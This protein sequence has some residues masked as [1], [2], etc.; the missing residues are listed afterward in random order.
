[1]THWIPDMAGLSGPRY[2]AI[3]D[4]LARDIGNGTLKPAT[5]LPTHRDLA[6]KLGVTVGTV[7]RA[8]TE[9]ERRGLIAGEVG[10]GTYVCEPEGGGTTV[11]GY[12][13]NATNATINMGISVPTVLEAP[14]LVRGVLRDIAAKGD[15][16][17]LL[18]YHSEP[19]SADSRNAA[20]RWLAD[21]HR[22][23]VR[24]EDLRAINGAQHGMLTAFIAAARPGD[25]IVSEILTYTGLK[26]VAVSLG[27]RLE[28]L[29]YD[30]DGLIPA[31]F[32]ACC[33]QRAPRVLYTVPTLHNPTTAI[34]PSERRR[35]IAAIARRYGVIIIEDDVFGFLPTQAPEPLYNLLPEQVIFLS[36]FSKCIGTGFRCGYMAVPPAMAGRIDAAMLTSQSMPPMLLIEIATRL[37][38][39]GAADAL[40][41]GQRDEARQRQTIA[42]D[43][44]AGLDVSTHP[45]SH[46]LWL[47]LPLPWRREA[48]AAEA[49]RRGVSVTP[50]DVF[51]VGHA[52]SEQAVRIS[53]CQP[54][55]RAQVERGLT[56]L[57]DL[58]AENAQFASPGLLAVV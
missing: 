16:E 32:E 55:D 4:A 12:Y 40:A 53:L 13:K 19:L 25:L 5:R 20:T 54:E 18:G 52:P 3:A 23:V 43:V 22:L 48:F 37:I 17:W 21:R 24:P 29:D 27:L 46:H 2:R 34:L 56:I 10:R 1:M 45:E 47:R 42:V 58:L 36:S 30:A 49:R 44:L 7:T 6:Y 26:H 14:T 39:S 11:I 38:L 9:A 35:E 41:T 28:G 33:R 57:A 8:Y 51:T 50:A 31:A 15:I